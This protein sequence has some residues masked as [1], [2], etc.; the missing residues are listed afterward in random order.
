M[1]LYNIICVD[2][3]IIGAYYNTRIYYRVDGEPT[4]GQ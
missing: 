2:T 3:T 4:F 1:R